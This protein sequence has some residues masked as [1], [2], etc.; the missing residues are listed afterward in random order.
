[1]VARKRAPPAALSTG[2][3]ALLRV[4]G[5]TA[6]AGQ[7]IVQLLFRLPDG[8]A[9]SPSEPLPA[10]LRL[11]RSARPTG[12]LPRGGHSISQ[13][14][15]ATQ[16]LDATPFLAPAQGARGTMP[17]RISATLLRH[18]WLWRAGTAR[19][20]DQLRMILWK[21]GSRRETRRGRRTEARRVFG[22]GVC[23]RG[24]R[25]ENTPQTLFRR[26]RQRKKRCRRSEAPSRQTPCLL[27]PRAP[28]FAPQAGENG[29]RAGLTQ[30]GRSLSDRHSGLPALPPPFTQQ[31]ARLSRNNSLHAFPPPRPTLLLWEKPLQKPL[32]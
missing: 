5:G 6:G 16:W 32:H 26:P 21:T 15:R 30:G 17:P 20:A 27:H 12:S 14:A 22:G 31:I 29:E 8:R 13:P 18:S 7:E 24:I 23:Q 19:N 10:P 1:M 9:G 28:C 3:D 2:R 11:A 4:R 25:S